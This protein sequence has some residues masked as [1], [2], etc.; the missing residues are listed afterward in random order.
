MSTDSRAKL[1]TEA[2]KHGIRHEQ[3][4]FKEDAT[5]EVRRLN[6]TEIMKDWLSSTE[7]QLRQRNDSIRALNT[8]LEAYEALVLPSEQ[9]AAELRSQWP[10]IK[11]VTLARADSSVILLLSTEPHKPLQDEDINRIHN[12]LS[13]RL[14]TPKVEIIVR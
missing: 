14:Q 12:W 6:E 4:I 13:V 11:D 2:E 5:I 3:I 1:Y 9:I 10:E 7:E 8:R